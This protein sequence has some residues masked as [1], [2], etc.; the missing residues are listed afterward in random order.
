MFSA[1]SCIAKFY[2][3]T[4]SQVLALTPQKFWAYFREIEVLAAKEQLAAI[5]VAVFTKIKGS[6]RKKVVQEL[7]EI[8]DPKLK[9]RAEKE[10]D[11]KIKY[12]MGR[13]GGKKKMKSK[14]KKGKKGNGA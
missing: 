6:D 4:E 7:Q 11:L 1:I 12:W 3:W 10:N 5:K 14:K 2:G 13:F 8:V 9:E